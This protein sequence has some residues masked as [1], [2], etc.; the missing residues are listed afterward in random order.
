M[1]LLLVSP[2]LNIFYPSSP[3]LFMLGNHL[4]ISPWTPKFNLILCMYSLLC[5]HF[6]HTQL[7]VGIKFSQD[8]FFKKK[9]FFHSPDSKIFYYLCLVYWCRAWL[10]KATRPLDSLSLHFFVCSFYCRTWIYSVLYFWP[11]DQPVLLF[12]FLSR[13]IPIST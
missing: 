10:V 5:P 1:T 4:N 3:L 8:I 12:L 2:I 13:N 11:T 9:F 6:K 7:T